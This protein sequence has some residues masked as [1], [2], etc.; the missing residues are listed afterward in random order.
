MLLLI[1][2]WHKNFAATVAILFC[3][4]RVEGGHNP[5]TLDLLSQAGSSGSIPGWDSA[6]PELAAI[7]DNL[8]KTEQHLKGKF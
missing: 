1:K 6:S 2:E 3:F 4:A 8:K 5:A 7:L